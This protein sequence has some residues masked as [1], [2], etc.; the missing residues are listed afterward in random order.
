MKERRDPAASSA[1][2]SFFT[3]V[4]ALVVRDEVSILE[5]VLVGTVHSTLQ[6]WTYTGDIN[7]AEGKPIKPMCLHVYVRPATIESFKALNLQG[8]WRDDN[9][10]ARHS[11]SP[12]VS[13]KQAHV[14]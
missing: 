8:A 1:R 4:G 14:G 2:V 13:N 7:A 5:C 12:G 9:K 6:V 11:L 10:D 3:L